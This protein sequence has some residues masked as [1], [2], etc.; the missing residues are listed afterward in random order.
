MD[1]SWWA[2]DWTLEPVIPCCWRR[3]VTLYEKT[4]V[5]EA[6][7]KIRCKNETDRNVLFYFFIIFMSFVYA[8]FDRIN[9]LI[10]A[11]NISFA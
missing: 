8:I 3:K 10:I 1:V 4:Q 7:N 9:T 5:F 11:W 6:E 2:G